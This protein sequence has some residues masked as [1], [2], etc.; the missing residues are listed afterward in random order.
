MGPH[1]RP[2][3]L[4]YKTYIY[5]KIAFEHNYRSDFYYEEKYQ[6]ALCY[7]IMVFVS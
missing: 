3:F 4:K 2:L 6:P 5:H 7:Y 1:E